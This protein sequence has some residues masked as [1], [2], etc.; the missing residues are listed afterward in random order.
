MRYL[1]RAADR[2]TQGRINCLEIETDEGGVVTIEMGD[3]MLKE[4]GMAVVTLLLEIEV[5][6]R[7]RQAFAWESDEGGEG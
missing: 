4:L 1:F 7:T 5:E 2:P 3:A 6:D